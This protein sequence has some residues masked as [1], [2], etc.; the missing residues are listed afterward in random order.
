M[1]K[2]KILI[3]IR[4]REVNPILSNMSSDPIHTNTCVN[5]NEYLTIG[6]TLIA[7]NLRVCMGSLDFT[8]LTSNA[9][10]HQLE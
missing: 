6:K 8:L 5:S 7:H 4:K 3:Q 1:L 2:K 9:F 10:H